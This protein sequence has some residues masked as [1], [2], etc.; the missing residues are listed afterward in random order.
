VAIVE[1]SKGISLK[2][3]SREVFLDRWGRKSFWGE[4]YDSEAFEEFVWKGKRYFTW[5]LSPRVSYLGIYDEEPPQ[6]NPMRV[7]LFKVFRVMERLAGGP[8]YVGNDIVD[9]K[10][11][12][13][14][15]AEA[16][17]L[18]SSLDSL[19]PQWREVADRV[20]LD[21]EVFFIF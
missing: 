3:F 6:E 16:F 7:L 21:E 5:A 15:E 17:H 11:P 10:H 18:P 1:N 14:S 12:E 8:I 4:E 13:S 9:S 20:E 19:W 2:E